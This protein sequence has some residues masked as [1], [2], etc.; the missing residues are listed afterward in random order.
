MEQYVKGFIGFTSV[1]MCG[2]SPLASFYFN[3][4][5]HGEPREDI[6]KYGKPGENVENQGKHRENKGNA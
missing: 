2:L 3:T 4:E 6:E 1:K 5:K